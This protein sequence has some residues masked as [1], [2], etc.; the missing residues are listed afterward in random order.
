MPDIQGTYK[1]GIDA[2]RVGQLVNTEPHVLISRTVETAAGVA[3]GKVVQQGTGD[4]G[5]KADLTGM[6]ADSFLGIVARERSTNPETP[7]KFAQYES[8][9]IVRQGVVVVQASKAITAG[10][11][12]TVALAS[13]DLNSDAV[14]AGQVALPK[15]RWESSTSGAGLA[16]IRLG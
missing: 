16:K 1:T 14:G 4:N 11:D 5:C 8:A 3:F 12:V 15:A 7:D 2:F 6:T 10:T 9:R 13:G